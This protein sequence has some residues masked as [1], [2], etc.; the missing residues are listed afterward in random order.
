MATRARGRFK[1]KIFNASHEM[2]YS[3]FYSGICQ[4]TQLLFVVASQIYVPISL[5]WHWCVYMD[6]CVCFVCA[7]CVCDL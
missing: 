3:D 2:I 5:C 7:V 1:L 4:Q 6:P